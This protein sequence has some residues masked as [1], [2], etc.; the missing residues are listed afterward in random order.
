MTARILVAGIG[1]IFL[2]DDGFGP[3]VMRHAVGQPHSD[4]VHLVDYGIR[5]MHLAYDLLE[6]WRALVLVDA[7]PDRGAPGTLHVFEADH[8]TLSATAGLEA[9]SM[10][11]AA[12]F[13]TLTALGGTA[14]P[15]IVV[16]CQVENVDEG[17]GL[18][19]LVSAAVPAAVA[20]INDVLAD[21][22]VRT[23]ADHTTTSAEG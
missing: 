2:G 17:M 19:E 15:T 3:E 1:N 7:L 16:G 23:L 9:H 18:S 4:D 10:D 8:E 22:A 6:E 21:L 12:A 20:A 5:G 13:A 14:P 11:P